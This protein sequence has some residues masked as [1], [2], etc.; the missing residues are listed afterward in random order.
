MQRE[1]EIRIAP[2]SADGDRQVDAVHGPVDR[3]REEAHSLGLLFR[4]LGDDATT[5]VR[6]EVA[7][8]RL[9]I[10][11]EA[12]AITSDLVQVGAA[13]TVALLGALALT[14]FLIL[15]LGDL[16]DSYWAGALIVGALFLIGGGLWARS[17]AKDLSEHAHLPEQTV[18]TLR[19]DARWAKHEAREFK[20]E[21][22][23]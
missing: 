1:E 17:A 20:R 12:R 2:G 5:L 19:E 21:V 23:P 8:A 6:E 4:R 13:L 15:L 18:D 14:A 22:K 11:R 16:L 3:A 7:L 9:E 10:R